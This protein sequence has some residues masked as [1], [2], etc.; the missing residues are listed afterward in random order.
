MPEDDQKKPWQEVRL[1]RMTALLAAC[2]QE[3]LGAELDIA[4]KRDDN[5][6]RPTNQP[7]T[8]MNP[9][10]LREYLQRE[11]WRLQPQEPMPVWLLKAPGHR[12]TTVI[13]PQS[14]QLAN[15]HLRMVQAIQ[16]V[17]DAQM[18]QPAEI[19]LDLQAATFDR[20][21]ITY[22]P[23]EPHW[24]PGPTAFDHAALIQAALAMLKTAADL[25]GNPAAAAQTISLPT[26]HTPFL[27]E[28]ALP[29]K[30]ERPESDTMTTLM[31]LLAGA[32]ESL[33]QDDHQTGGHT[34]FAEQLANLIART[35]GNGVSLSITWSLDA[36]TPTPDQKHAFR[37]EWDHQLALLGLNLPTQRATA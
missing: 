32:Q 28:L 7:T 24:L 15:Y 34:Q 19:A 1:G 23:P 37:F 5:L 21:R 3:D 25:A 14:Q 17:A 8:A 27:T 11:G 29:T 9:A 13:I 6:S 2:T 35:D 4:P 16:Q 30:S 26:G 20:L 22:G 31:G 33:A 12:H 36:P 18:K 10:H